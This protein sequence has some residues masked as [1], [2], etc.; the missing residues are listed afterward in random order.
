MALSGLKLFSSN[1]RVAYYVYAPM[2]K[3]PRRGN[4]N[5]LRHKPGYSA[6]DDGERLELSDLG[7]RGVVLY[8]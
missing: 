1:G 5:Q 8:V 6:S 2:P 4:S 3:E 7:S